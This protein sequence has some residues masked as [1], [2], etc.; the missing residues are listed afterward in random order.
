MIEDLTTEFDKLFVEIKVNSDDMWSKIKSKIEQEEAFK[1]NF[2]GLFKLLLQMRNAD[3]G[4]K[5][6]KYRDFI[7]SP[8]LDSKGEQ[9]FSSQYLDSSQESID[10]GN[11]PVHLS[12]PV[13]KLLP[14]DSDANGAY[15]IARKGKIVVDKIVREEDL[16]ISEGTWLKFAQEQDSNHERTDTN[17]YDC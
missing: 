6:A 13:N 15:N 11:L 5:E 16:K 2:K 8:V 3:P 14:E 17:L 12:S 1:L 10:M 7:I 9:Y 4:R